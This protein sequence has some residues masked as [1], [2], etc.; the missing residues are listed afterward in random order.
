MSLL[1][2]VVL[3]DVVEIV[4]PDDDSPLHLLAL[5][6]AS[7]DPSANAHI[8]SKWTLLVDVCSFTSLECGRNWGEFKITNAQY[9]AFWMLN[10]KR[11]LDL[12]DQNLSMVVQK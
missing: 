2:S 1:E 12:G 3:L 4:S 9:Y 10:W 7:Q 5:D 6:N 8:S 11:G